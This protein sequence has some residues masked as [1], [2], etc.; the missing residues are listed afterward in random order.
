MG[1]RPTIVLAAAC[2]AALVPS[3][4]RAGGDPPTLAVCGQ[5]LW[6][7]SE[8]GLIE[9]NAVTGRTLRTLRTSRPYA[10]GVVCDAGHAYVT[11]VENGFVDG[12]VDRFDA[13]RGRRTR[14]SH[15]AGGVFGIAL[16]FGR[17]FVIAGGARRR[18]VELAHGPR[19]EHS[20]RLPGPAWI[21]GG[22]DLAIV[23]EDRDLRLRS[24]DG[25]E[26]VVASAIDGPAL[27]C[28]SGVLAV[29]RGH[30]SLIGSPSAWSAPFTAEAITCDA[31]AAWV[32]TSDDTGTRTTTRRLRIGDGRVTRR[33]VID[34]IVVAAARAQRVIWLVTGGPTIRLV[35]LDPE[36]LAVVSS[37]VIA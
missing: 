30:L 35:G 12:T 34:G 17:V 26:R 31:A 24:L 16:A 18:V 36:T 3:A 2:V 25:R 4:A 7:T 10:T 15:R 32:A 37:R 14:I 5:T 28:P 33:V 6:L 19:P 21:S 1:R 29:S 22:R 23:G 8:A 27:L 9:A 11:S 20:L 13:R